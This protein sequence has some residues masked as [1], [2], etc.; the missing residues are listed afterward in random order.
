[1]HQR[2]A[3]LAEAKAKAKAWNDETNPRNRVDDGAYPFTAEASKERHVEKSD[4]N[5]KRAAERL[6]CTEDLAAEERRASGAEVTIKR[7]E[8][9][10]ASAKKALAAAKTDKKRAEKKVRSLKTKLRRLA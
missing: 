4:R 8:G 5:G 2:F 6:K 3:T 9:E 7:S 10:I 1:M